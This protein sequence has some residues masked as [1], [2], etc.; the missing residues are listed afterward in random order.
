MF[1]NLKFTIMIIFDT[2]TMDQFHVDMNIDDLMGFE[3]DL[4]QDDKEDLD[5]DYLYT[6][7]W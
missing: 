1:N 3:E 6:L 5:I 4:S 2:N 7:Y